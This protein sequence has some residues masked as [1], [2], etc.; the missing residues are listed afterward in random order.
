M[1]EIKSLLQ[2]KVEEKKKIIVKQ[3]TPTP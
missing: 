3:A 2:P 1:E